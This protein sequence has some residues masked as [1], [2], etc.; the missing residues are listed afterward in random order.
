MKP[1]SNSRSPDCGA[2]RKQIPL[3]YGAI[4]LVGLAIYILACTAFSPDDSKVLVTAA[5]PRSG[6]TTVLL[7]DR[8]TGQLDPLFVP[9]WMNGVSEKGRDPLMVRPQWTPD[10]RS[11][12][13]IWSFSDVLADEGLNV[14]VLPLDHGRPVRVLTL[15]G[16]EDSGPSLVLPLAVVKQNLFLRAQT[17][18][19]ARIN[20]ETGEVRTHLVEGEK[21]VLMPSFDGDSVFYVVEVDDEKA[22]YEFGRLD[23]GT[24]AQKPLWRFSSADEVRPAIGPEGDRLALLDIDDGNLKLRVLGAG[25]TERTFAWPFGELEFKVGMPVFSP[26]ADRLYACYS[27]EGEEE[28]SGSFGLLEI[29]VGDAPLRKIPLIQNVADTDESDVLLVAASLSHDGGTA[30]V[31]TGY[32]PMDR[33]RKFRAADCALFLIDLTREDRKVK[34]VLL[35]MLPRAKPDGE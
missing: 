32:L 33:D 26:N 4:A 1:A 10:G 18:L 5:D 6:D 34:K 28:S 11:I 9:V 35:P 2:D 30:A 7:Y 27:S 17:N 8:G 31:S 15:P 21:P 14:A 12:L 16:V 23:P 24:F 3:R 22:A 20:L 13:A 19:V 29:P 25:R